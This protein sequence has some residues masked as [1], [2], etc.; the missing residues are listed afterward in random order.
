[1]EVMVNSSTHPA[2]PSTWL[3]GRPASSNN[4]AES[5]AAT[6]QEEYAS[7]IHYNAYSKQRNGYAPRVVDVGVIA[8]FLI[9]RLAA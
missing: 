1:L 5:L 4:D 6:E 3:R 7:D 2:Q 8:E 9:G